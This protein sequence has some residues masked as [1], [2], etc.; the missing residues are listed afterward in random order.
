[1]LPHLGAGAGQG[2]EDA[3]ALVQLLSHSQT[4][5][6]NVEHVLQ[7]YDSIRRPRANMVHAESTFIG[8][9]YESPGLSGSTKEGVVADFQKI[10]LEI[11]EKVLK[12]DMT[13][14]VDLAV[15]QL[16]RDGVFQ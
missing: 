3:F 14:D 6:D 5:R 15:S 10:W 12:H 11:W 4:R 9:T 13:A 2:I 1:M 16:V 7:A 8:E